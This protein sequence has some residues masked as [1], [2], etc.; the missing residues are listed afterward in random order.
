LQEQLKKISAGDLPQNLFVAPYGTAPAVLCAVEIN[1]TKTLR[2]TGNANL[3]PGFIINTPSISDLLAGDRITITGRLGDGVPKSDWAMVIDRFFDSSNYSGLSQHVTPEHGELFS[4]TYLLDDDDLKFPLLI[5]SN[6]WG[7]SVEPMNYFVDSI[8]VTRETSEARYIKDAR[9]LI[10]SLANDENI[11]TLKPGDVTRFLRSSGT[12][13]YTIFERDGRKGMKISRRINNWDGI[14]ISLAGM[15]LK[16]GN[17]YTVTV[18]GA[19]DGAAPQDARM[20]LQL[21]PE[22]IWRSEIKA[23][24]DNEF[25][26]RHTLSAMELQ[27]TE[28]IRIA[29]CDDGAK[30]S[31]NIFKIEITVSA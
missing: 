11:Q 18:S 12:P 8:L 28:F 24:D 19:I 21:L 20:M 16:Q 26:L 23:R 30:M 5:R 25:T 29:S 15:N 1:K 2:V 4:M 7:K 13:K 17:R 3:K 14:D 27:T 10:Y 9:E 6:H 31:F 22:F